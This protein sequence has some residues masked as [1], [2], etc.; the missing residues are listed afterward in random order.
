MEQEIVWFVQSVN[1]DEKA[2]LCGTEQE[3]KDKALE[4]S[5]ENGEEYVVYKGVSTWVSSPPEEIPATLT[6]IKKNGKKK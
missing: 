4:L 5:E 1:I 2:E 3:A 6:K